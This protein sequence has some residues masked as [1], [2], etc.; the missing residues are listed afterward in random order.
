MLCLFLFRV[1]FL[2]KQLF[3]ACAILMFNVS[4]IALMFVLFWRTSLLSFAIKSFG[5]AVFERT[6]QK[7]ARRKNENKILRIG[8][9]CFVQSCLLFR[10]L[11]CCFCIWFTGAIFFH[12]FYFISLNNPMRIRFSLIIEWRPAFFCFG[13]IVW[14]RL[15][16]SECLERLF[17]KS[18]WELNNFSTNYTKHQLKH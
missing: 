18:H 13:S 10:W 3:S 15:Y 12:S 8:E 2:F 11:N 17:L 5:S 6:T 9:N 1:F 14:V 7:R 4:F 16:V